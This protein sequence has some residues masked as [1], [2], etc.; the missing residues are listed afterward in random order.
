MRSLTQRYQSFCQDWKISLEITEKVKALVVEKLAVDEKIV[1]VTKLQ[2][3]KKK[4]LKY[5]KSLDDDDPERTSL[6]TTKTQLTN[7]ETQSIELRNK[8][9]DLT[10]QAQKYMRTGYPELVAHCQSETLHKAAKTG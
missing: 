5:L 8:Q 4:K 6:E 10:F 7:L 1:V 2:N 9:A 3:S